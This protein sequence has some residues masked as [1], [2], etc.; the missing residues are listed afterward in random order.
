[1]QEQTYKDEITGQTD[2]RYM[3]ELELSQSLHT[4]QDTIDSIR[5]FMED[6]NIEQVNKGIRIIR[7]RVV[8]LS[9][10]KKEMDAQRKE[11]AERAWQTETWDGHRINNVDA[12]M[13]YGF[14][15][16]IDMEKAWQEAGLMEKEAQYKHQIGEPSGM[17]G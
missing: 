2:R 8:A 14:K 3:T 9:E 12:I 5:R 1:M 10:I 17:R 13:V 16:R 15:S 6:G 7:N 11:M 4:I